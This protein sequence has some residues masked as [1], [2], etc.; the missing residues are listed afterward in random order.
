MNVAVPT[1]PSRC[2]PIAACRTIAE[3]SPNH[4]PVRAGVTARPHREAAAVSSYARV[5]RSSAPFQPPP[6]PP[7][8][9]PKLPRARAAMS[10]P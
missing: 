8:R 2:L 5:T 1:V 6:R 10:T 7:P 3:P 9:P 4:R